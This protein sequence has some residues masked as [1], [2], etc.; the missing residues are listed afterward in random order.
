[1]LVCIGV[2]RSGSRIL[3]TSRL[4]VLLGMQNVGGNP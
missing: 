4:E 2:I 3:A 1:M